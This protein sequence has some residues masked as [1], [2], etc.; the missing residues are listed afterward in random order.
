MFRNSEKHFCLEFTFAC[1]VPLCVNEMAESSK[2]VKFGRQ[3]KKLHKYVDNKL[4]EIDF[5][6]KIFSCV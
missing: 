1:I 5:Y 4:G 2:N 3:K 6:V